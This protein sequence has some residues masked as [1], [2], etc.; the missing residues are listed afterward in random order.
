MKAAL[1]PL[2]RATLAINSRRLIVILSLSS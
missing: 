2:V 1:K